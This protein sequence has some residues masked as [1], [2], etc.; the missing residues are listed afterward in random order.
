MQ[1][2]TPKGVSYFIKVGR[3]DGHVGQCDSYRV[4]VRSQPSV[5]ALHE[6]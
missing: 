3:E 6:Y 1:V 5:Q 4:T 2:L